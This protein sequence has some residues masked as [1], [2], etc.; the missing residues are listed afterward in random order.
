MQHPETG[1][2]IQHSAV[3]SLE[4]PSPR[5]LRKLHPFKSVQKKTHPGSHTPPDSPTL[6]ARKFK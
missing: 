2:E 6:P 4:H 5:P 1:R 3:S